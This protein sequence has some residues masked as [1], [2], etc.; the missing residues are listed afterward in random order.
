[1]KPIEINGRR[2]WYWGIAIICFIYAGVSFLLFVSQ[3]YSVYVRDQVRPS[4]E[5]RENQAESFNRTGFRGGIPP[6]VRGYMLISLIVEFLGT[7]ITFIAG[8][9]L[10][11]LL[12]V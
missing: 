11:N 10:V 12:R 9:S 6:N 1:M 2:K 3:S 5:A 7:F 4:F 8:L